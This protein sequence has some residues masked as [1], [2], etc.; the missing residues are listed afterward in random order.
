MPE[1][2]LDRN[3][4]LGFSGGE[5]KKSE[6]LQMK[7]LKPQ[8]AII[9]EVD[10]GLD[11]DSL[12]MIAQQIEE[13]RDGKFSGLLVTHYQRILNHVQPDFV[14]VMMG[15]KIVKS[16][17]RELVKEIEENGYGSLNVH[18]EDH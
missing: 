16:G 1:S 17:S 4:N 12:K 8:F 7:T 2:V 13:M 18:K 14:H 6:I 11:I 3:L 15:G 9:D 5:K 10:S